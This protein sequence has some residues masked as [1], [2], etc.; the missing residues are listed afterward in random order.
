MKK[1]FYSTILL[2]VIASQIF[3]QCGQR[4]KDMIFSAVTKTT[5]TYSV[6]PPYDKM[7]IYQP[8]GDTLA[9]RP[10][11]ILAHGGSFIGGSKSTDAT[12]N[13]LCSNF[14]KRGY[15]TASIDYRLGNFLQMLD[16]SQAIEVVLKAISD[17]KSA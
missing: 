5:V 12:V 16:S 10:V 3:A 1:N 2:M 7:D 14:A 9:M 4:Y 13:A 6:Y 15:V 11:I 8:T 17:G